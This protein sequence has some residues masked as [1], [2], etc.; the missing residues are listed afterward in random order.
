MH[1]LMA[2]YSDGFTYESDHLVAVFEDED[3]AKLVAEELD[4]LAER[5]GDSL[6]DLPNCGFHVA[7]VVVHKA[8]SESRVRGIVDEI[9][10]DSFPRRGP[11]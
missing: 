6:R 1:A 3:V 9:L 5:Q 8:S 11:A 2:R 7:P 10:R 4:R